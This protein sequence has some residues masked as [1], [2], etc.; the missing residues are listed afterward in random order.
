MTHGHIAASMGWHKIITGMVGVFSVCLE[1]S[2]S[3]C[4][5]GL[6]GLPPKSCV[7]VLTP[8]TS[9]TDTVF[10]EKIKLKGCH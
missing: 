4:C 3:Y 6:K 5:Y 10:V 2:V 1:H 9:Y 8:S 7:E